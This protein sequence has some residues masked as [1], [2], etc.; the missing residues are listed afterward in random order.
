MLGL[1]DQFGK[2]TADG[3]DF[4]RVEYMNSLHAFTTEKRAKILEPAD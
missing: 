1:D 2:M 4:Q 3:R